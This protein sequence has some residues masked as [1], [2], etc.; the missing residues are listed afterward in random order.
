MSSLEDEVRAALH[1]EGERLRPVRPLRLP[2]SD[3][4]QGLRPWPVTRTP[5]RVRPGAWLV[6]VLAAAV[7]VLVAVGLVTAQAILGGPAENPARPAPATT[8][9]PT[10]RYYVS[11]TGITDVGNAT[12][13]VVGDAR[14]GAR[15]AT[16]R[17]PKGAVFVGATPAGA[18]DDRTFAVGEAGQELP[19]H[20]PFSTT[21]T[22]GWYLL[23]IIPGAHSQ[24]QM[25][26]LPIQPSAADGVPASVALSADGTNLAVLSSG[27]SGANQALRVYSVSSG[28]LLHIWWI[29]RKAAN[30]QGASDLSW[31][32]GD[33]T[34]A[35]ALSWDEDSHTQMRT[36]DLAA[37]GADLL[38]D[39]HVVWSQYVALPPNDV[40]TASTP[41]PCESPFLT[42]D[43][44]AVVCASSSYSARGNRASLVWLS[45][46]LSAPAAPRLLGRVPLPPG[47]RK[48]SGSSVQWANASGT[49]VIGWW[50]TITVGQVKNGNVPAT[51]DTY[52]GVVGGGTVKRLNTGTIQPSVDE[53][54]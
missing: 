25:T 2:P 29:T 24:V 23:K 9:G 5:R 15:L 54:W 43:G 17:A 26:R 41:R 27:V 53:G 22:R 3:A 38:A 4:R 47:Q 1:S 11:P 31:L 13:L 14:T 21:S 46:A 28:R 32:A 49:E 35:F 33:T 44:Q 8:T 7:V 45:Y 36:L 48:G 10:P 30:D 34:V 16:I 42:S 40:Y 18:A 50:Q 20:P 19:S 37:G 12:T 6:P 51:I 39:S 52:V